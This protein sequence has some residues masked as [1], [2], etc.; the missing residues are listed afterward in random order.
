MYHSALHTG[1]DSSKE[2][3]I[4]AFPKSVLQQLAVVK[5]VQW[6]FLIPLSIH[7]S[8]GDTTADSSARLVFPKSLTISFG[9]HR[10]SIYGTTAA[11]NTAAIAAASKGVVRE[12]HARKRMHK[13]VH[14]KILDEDFPDYHPKSSGR[15]GGRTDPRHPAMPPIVETCT[16]CLRAKQTHQR[17]PRHNE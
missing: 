16:I 8:S 9:A 14:P 17:N 12:T 6:P 5:E 7:L 10:A 2:F 13:P 11:A 1:S 15:Y 4:H 3:G